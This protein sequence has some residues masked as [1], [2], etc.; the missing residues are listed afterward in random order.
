MS[1]NH[2]TPI[3]MPMSNPTTKAECTPEQAYA[4]SDGRAVVATGS[5]FNPVKLP[6]GRTL[7][8]SQCNNVRRAGPSLLPY[9]VTSPLPYFV[10]VRI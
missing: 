8:P 1:E 9:F 4:W 6:D 7:I 3:V 2:K 5:P 10:T